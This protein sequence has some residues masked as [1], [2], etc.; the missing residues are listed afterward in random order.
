MHVGL[1]PDHNLETHRWRLLE[2]VLLLGLGEIDRSLP[3]RAVEA[4]VGDLAEPLRRS[5]G[6]YLDAESR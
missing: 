2:P 1:L 6:C 3:C 4:D 5:F